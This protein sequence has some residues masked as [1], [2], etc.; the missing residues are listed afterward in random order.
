MLFRSATLAAVRWVQSA[1]E[2][3]AQLQAAV[4]RFR[5]GAH[6]L[7]LPLLPSETAIQPLLVGDSLQAMTLADAMRARGFWISAMRPPTVPK[8]EARLRIT[9][10]AAHDEQQVD[11]MLQALVQEWSRCVHD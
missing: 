4:R 1:D 6:A 10:T 3:R 9:L 2:P 7:G 5:Q 11:A 8:G